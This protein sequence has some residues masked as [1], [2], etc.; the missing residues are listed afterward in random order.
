MA[1]SGTLRMAAV[2]MLLMLAGQLL[3]ATPAAAAAAT[4]AEV[5][6]GLGAAAA[7]EPI[8]A[9]PGCDTHC[10]DICLGWCLACPYEFIHIHPLF[11]HYHC[12]LDCQTM[13]HKH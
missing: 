3:P 8:C 4:T 6:R 13:K 9:L 1:S 5:R 10:H 7:G 12:F 2:L 11:C